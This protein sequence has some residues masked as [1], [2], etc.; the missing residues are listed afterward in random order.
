V[1][2]TRAAC[3]G[4]VGAPASP[5]RRASR[6]SAGGLYRDGSQPRAAE[7]IVGQL[8]VTT[9][10]PAPCDSRREAHTRDEESVLSA[11]S[12]PPSRCHDSPH[13]SLPPPPRRRSPSWPM[14]HRQRP[15]PTPEWITVPARAATQRSGNAPGCS[16]GHR[17]MRNRAQWVWSQPSERLRRRC[18]RARV[19]RSSAPPPEA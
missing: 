5:R 11:S 4:V 2:R 14:T 9:H 15:M 7:Q 13:R 6:L 17:S 16:R 1:R 10:P 18:Y 8:P 19:A 3:G 12:E